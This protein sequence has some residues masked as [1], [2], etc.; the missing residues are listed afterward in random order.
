MKR[1]NVETSFAIG[2]D[3]GTGEG[4]EEVGALKVGRGTAVEE[5][6]ATET[7]SEVDVERGG[8]FKMKTVVGLQPELERE[9]LSSSRSVVEHTPSFV[10]CLVRVCTMVEKQFDGE[11]EPLGRGDVKGCDSP[12]VSSVDLDV[13]LDEIE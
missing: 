7:V 4:K 3:D 11:Q 6:S 2:S 1:T 12:R 8:G 5:G 9:E 13:C 10:V